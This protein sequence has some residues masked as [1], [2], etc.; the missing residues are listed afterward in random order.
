MGAKCGYTRFTRLGR[1]HCPY[2]PELRKIKRRT[3]EMKDEKK[4]TLYLKVRVSPEEMAAIKK[5]F[6]NSGMSSLSTFVR[7]MIFEGYIAQVNENEL[8]ELT[9]IANNV[10][11]NINQIAHRANVTNKIYK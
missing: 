3:R 4:R 9:R 10:A 5:K 2:D 7:A 11:N 1:G 6:E 8:K